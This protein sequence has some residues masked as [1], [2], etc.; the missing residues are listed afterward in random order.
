MLDYKVYKNLRIKPY[1]IVIELA[2][3]HI[4][5]YKV[6]VW[7]NVVGTPTSDSGSCHVAGRF[8]TLKEAQGCAERSAVRRGIPCVRY[9]YQVYKG[10]MWGEVVIQPDGTFPWPRS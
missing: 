2:D 7:Q 5:P 10:Q 4:K 6:Y 3:S 8:V 9:G 1:S